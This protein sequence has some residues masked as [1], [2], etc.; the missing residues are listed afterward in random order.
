MPSWTALDALKQRIIC[1]LCGD[2][3]DATRQLVNA[4]WRYRRSGVLGM[5]KN[6]QGAVPVALTLQQLESNVD[7]HRGIYSPSLSL[8]PKAGIDLPKCEI[9]FVW[10]VP[11]RYGREET[12]VVLAECKDRGPIK[13]DEF[14]KDVENLRRVADALPHERVETFVLLSKLSP[15]TAEEVKEAATLNDKYYRRVI[16]LTERELEP[17]MIYERTKLD[18]KDIR[19]YASTPEDLAQTTAEIYFRERIG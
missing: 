6:A 19:E 11:P 1:E 4:Q 10:V 17:Y 2:E 5:E 14:K 12:V 13:L 8:E 7:L 18:F 15:F 16:L 3:Y 9:D